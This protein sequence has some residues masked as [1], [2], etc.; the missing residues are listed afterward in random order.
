MLAIALNRWNVHHRKA[1]FEKSHSPL[2]TWG[3]FYVHLCINLLVGTGDVY[4]S[5]GNVYGDQHS[6]PI[7]I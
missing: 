3:F 4:L 6:H 1:Q 2:A 7:Y 5:W